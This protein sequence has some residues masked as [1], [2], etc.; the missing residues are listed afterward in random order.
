MHPT[1]G[2]RDNKG[3]QE[4]RDLLL[5]LQCTKQD[6]KILDEPAF[7]KPLLV[8]LPEDLQG[9]WQ[10]HTYRY[11]TQRMVDYP[12]FSEFARFVQKIA[13]EQNDPYLSIE[14]PER[15]NVNPYPVKTSVKPFR[16]LNAGRRL[17]VNKNKLEEPPTG[18]APTWDPNKW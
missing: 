14:V 5:G 7:L 17:T 1:I 16:P 13:G 9:R 6:G 11:K 8:K 12:P 15:R 2:L 3:L 10:R 4:L 18:E